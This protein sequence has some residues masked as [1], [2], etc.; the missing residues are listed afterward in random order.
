MDCSTAVINTKRLKGAVRPMFNVAKNTYAKFRRMYLRR[1]AVRKTPFSLSKRLLMVVFRQLIACPGAL[2]GVGDLHYRDHKIGGAIT[3]TASE[4]MLLYHLVKLSAYSRVCEVGSYVGWSTVHIALALREVSACAELTC[5]DP[6]VESS[7]HIR[8]ELVYET[9]NTNIAHA[10]VEDLIRVVRGY[11][12]GALLKAAPA[13]GWELAFL[14]GWHLDGQPLRDILGIVR[15]I[16]PKGV[17]VLHDVWMP[18]VRDGLIYLLGQGWEG[19]ILATANF[20]TVLW[21]SGQRPPWLP[22]LVAIARRPPFYLE[23]CATWAWRYGLTA[24]SLD[25]T[26]CSSWGRREMKL[27]F[28]WEG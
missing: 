12:P 2:G 11:S 22:A 3:C 15:H 5:I 17:L 9:F 7:P 4:A 19:L 23:R 14:D 13:G 10:G 6:F 18:D 20:L 16:G 26:I 24:K 21:R 28:L 25:A 27:S 8:P 1:V